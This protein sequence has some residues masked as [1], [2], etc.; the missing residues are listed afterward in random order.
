MSK[1]CDTLAVCWTGNWLVRIKFFA[2][3]FSSVWHVVILE[4]FF[5]HQI[6]N[7][8]LFFWGHSH[9]FLDPGKIRFPDFWIPKKYEQIRTC[10]FWAKK[11]TANR[12]V[13]LHWLHVDE[14]EAVGHPAHPEATNQLGTCCG[15]NLT[16]LVT[17]RTS[18][19]PL[20]AYIYIYIDP[21]RNFHYRKDAPVKAIKLQNKL[22]L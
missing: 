17:L 4:S 12:Q 22:V 6:R 2:K 10:L 13:F 8:E 5:W 21:G 15:G 16:D 7:D 20:Y 19:H 14:D 1:A 18:G 3:L 9:T 11:A